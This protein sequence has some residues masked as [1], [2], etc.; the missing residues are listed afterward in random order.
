MR[1]LSAADISS[2]TSPRFWTPP[3]PIRR[4]LRGVRAA[5]RARLAAP[6]PDAAPADDD[7]DAE[8]LWDN[9]PL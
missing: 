3:L 6:E 4:A 8:D 9:V 5:M 1:D 7:A 2:T